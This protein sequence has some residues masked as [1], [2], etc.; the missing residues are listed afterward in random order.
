MAPYSVLTAAFLT[1]AVTPL[2]SRYFLELSIPLVVT[3]LVS[4]HVDLVA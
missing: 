1:Q 3:F 2:S 4:F